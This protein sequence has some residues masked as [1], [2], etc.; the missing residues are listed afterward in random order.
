[1]KLED[2]QRGLLN[3]VAEYRERECRRLLDEACL[4][5]TSDAADDSVLV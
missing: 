1:M 2:R 5:Y 3:L 4:L